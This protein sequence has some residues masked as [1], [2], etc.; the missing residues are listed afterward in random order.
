MSRAALI[1]RPGARDPGDFADGAIQFGW[2][3]HQADL[4]GLT[5]D[6]APAAAICPPDAIQLSMSS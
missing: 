6:R 1:P 3:D 4:L 5:P 2:T